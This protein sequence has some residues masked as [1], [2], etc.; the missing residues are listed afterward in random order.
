MERTKTGE[1]NWLDLSATDIEGQTK[2]YEGLLGWSHADIPFGNGAIYKMY[3]I[4]G[5]IVG[6]GTQMNP[7][8]LETGVPSA[9]NTYTRAEDVDATAER[10][11][12]LG[13]AVIMPAMDVA[14]TGRMVGIADPTGAAFFLWKPI[15]PEATMTYMEA[16][17][18]FWS[19]LN[20]RDPEKASDF[21]R[22]LFGWEYARLEQE[23]PYWQIIVDGKG[24]G[25]I[26]PMPKMVPAETSSYWLVYFA[27][28][29]I[30]ASVAKA[31]ELGASV[32]LE[33]TEVP[34]MLAFAVLADPA[35]ATFALGQPYVQG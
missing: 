24:E 1:F 20:T 33:P 7:A 6:G 28:D 4:D 11:V 29:D 25:G 10:A 34:D 3:S 5:K 22:K 9:W 21:Y 26:M 15:T 14:G 13:G 27:T 31:R 18:L 35:G 17:A 16:G 19:E 30:Q 32:L 23:M 2:F 8:L 12:A